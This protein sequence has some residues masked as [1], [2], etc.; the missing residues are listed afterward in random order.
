MGRLMNE[1]KTVSPNLYLALLAFDGERWCLP[2]HGLPGKG[3]GKS[4][5]DFG[6]ALNRLWVTTKE[7][8]REAVA[9]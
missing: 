9:A 7:T 3:D 6:E 8:V 2:V 1:S 5:L 4:W